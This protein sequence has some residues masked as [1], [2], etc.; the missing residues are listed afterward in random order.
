MDVLKSYTRPNMS[1]HP[2]HR[3]KTS[4]I[5][6]KSN[7]NLSFGINDTFSFPHSK[8]SDQIISVNPMNAK[9]TVIGGS[10][11]TVRGTWHGEG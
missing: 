1:P 2:K 8:T 5:S 4:N 10:L 11:Y 3:E 9:F 7:R 6:S